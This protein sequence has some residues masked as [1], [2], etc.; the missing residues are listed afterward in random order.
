MTDTTPHTVVKP[1]LWA[2]CN[3]PAG[4]GGY[5]AFNGVARLFAASTGLELHSIEASKIIED[6]RDTV[7][8][9]LAHL[10]AELRPEP[11]KGHPQMR[12]RSQRA[13]QEV[14]SEVFYKKHGAPHAILMSSSPDFIGTRDSSPSGD[15]RLKIPKEIFVAPHLDVT[16]W[17]NYLPDAH[18]SLAPHS[19]TV[20]G[21]ASEA[22]RFREA[23]K[24]DR[25]PLIAI[26]LSINHVSTER[27]KALGEIAAQKPDARFIISSSPRGIKNMFPDICDGFKALL[28]AEQQKH[29]IVYDFHNGDK[30]A[31][32]YQALLTLADHFIIIGHSESMVA[33]RLFAGRTAYYGYGYDEG[34]TERI[35]GAELTQSGKVKYFPNTGALM[36]EQFPSIDATSMIADSL[37]GYYKAHDAQPRE[38]IAVLEAIKD[39]MR[40]ALPVSLIS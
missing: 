12:S 34:I 40:R 8:T 16:A 15:V 5:H 35:Y 9:V 22:A 36:S 31:N 1:K 13:F 27:M 4:S 38:P 19:L 18:D 37:V 2:V 25:K 24:G 11:A 23:L 26:V 30:N 3:Y 28:N 32:P 6:F 21:L 17:R 10:P 33:E 20:E 7:E 29:L 14:V 39:K